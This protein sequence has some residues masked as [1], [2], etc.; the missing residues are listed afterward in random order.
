[1]DAIQRLIEDGRRDRERIK[2]LEEV[3][4]RLAE[5]KGIF[6]KLPEISGNVKVV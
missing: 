4:R 3:I 5:G 2:Q 1:M 6:S